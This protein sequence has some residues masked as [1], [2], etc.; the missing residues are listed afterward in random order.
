MISTL[1]SLWAGVWFSKKIYFP[2]DTWRQQLLLSFQFWIFCILLYWMIPGRLQVFHLFL[3][4]HKQFSL[5]TWSHLLLPFTWSSLHTPQRLM[6]LILSSYPLHN[7]LLMYLLLQSSG[8]LL[9]QADHHYDCRTMWP[10]AQNNFS[11]TLCLRMSFITDSNQL[12]CMHSQLSQ[13][14]QSQ[15]HLRKPLLIQNGYRLC[16]LR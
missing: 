5:I 9:D 1:T 3:L 11:P 2:S 16:S 13:L 14:C 8:D 7:L 6:K 10:K 12:I 4:S 15:R